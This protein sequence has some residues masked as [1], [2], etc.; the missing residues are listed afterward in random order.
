MFI[1]FRYLC[2]V[3]VFFCLHKFYRF[4][5]GILYCY[6]LKFVCQIRFNKIEKLWKF[7][8]TKKS[9]ECRAITTKKPETCV[10]GSEVTNFIGR[11]RKNRSLKERRKTHLKF[12]CFL[13]LW[14]ENVWITEWSATVLRMRKEKKKCTEKEKMNMK[15][16]ALEK[17][18]H[19]K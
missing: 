14:L 6:H 9:E 5:N 19:F 18:I 1:F 13:L 12:G 4:F 3:V 2:F 7:I 11:I 8:H 17:Y 10:A 16:K 15:N